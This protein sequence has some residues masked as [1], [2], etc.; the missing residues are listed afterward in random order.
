MDTE[1]SIA[2]TIRNIIQQFNSTT[3]TIGHYEGHFISTA[4]A[5]V[6]ESCADSL[7]HLESVAGIDT[8]TTSQITAASNEEDGVRA[9]RLEVAREIK[10]KQ[11]TL[12]KAIS[13]QRPTINLEIGKLLSERAK[14]DKLIAQ[15]DASTIA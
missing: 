3:I 15:F 4:Q 9:R 1:S 7:E 12:T 11:I 10:K 8:P 6:L 14:L 13:S 5:A 2:N